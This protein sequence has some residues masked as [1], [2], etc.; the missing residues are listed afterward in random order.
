MDRKSLCCFIPTK[1]TC[2]HRINNVK[3][4]SSCTDLLPYTALRGFVWLMGISIIMAN[5]LSM[6]YKSYEMNHTK[7][8]NSIECLEILGLN[9][10]DL[11]SGVYLFIIG[12]GDMYYRNKYVHYAKLWRAGTSCRVAG[13][14]VWFGVQMSSFILLLISVSRMYCVWKPFDIAIL[15]IP[16]LVLLVTLFSLYTDIQSILQQTLLIAENSNVCIPLQVSVLDDSIVTKLHN[17]IMFASVVLNVVCMLGVL[18]LNMLII[19]FSSKSRKSAGRERSRDDMIM[20]VRLFVI[21]STNFLTWIVALPL[22]VMSVAGYYIDPSITAWL[23]IV[24]IP[25]N[26]LINPVTYTFTTRAFRSWLRE[27]LTPRKG[28]EG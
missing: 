13:G 26:S 15:N 24:G 28:L 14:I 2:L 8:S 23:S 20:I 10:A 5:I 27:K 17:Y 1:A 12:S 11:L 3:G 21:S 7:K 19:F 25:M 6:A 16:K 9:F 18:V 22:S 4:L